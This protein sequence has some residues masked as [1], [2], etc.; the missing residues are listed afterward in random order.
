MQE[1]N[2]YATAAGQIVKGFSNRSGIPCG[3]LSQRQ[4]WPGFRR[5]HR[6]AISVRWRPIA[7]DFGIPKKCESIAE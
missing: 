7:L 6:T 5:R 2:V 1:T 3:D 4:T